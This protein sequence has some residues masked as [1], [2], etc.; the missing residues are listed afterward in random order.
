[1]VVNVKKGIMQDNSKK[2]T[3]SLRRNFLKLNFFL[4]YPLLTRHA[5]CICEPGFEGAH[6]EVNTIT[7]QNT[8][9]H[10]AAQATNSKMIGLIIGLIVML[11]LAGTAYLYFRDRKERKRARRKKRLRNAGIET[12][13]SFRGTSTGE[14]A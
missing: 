13:D 11:V 7:K 10:Y 1:M 9:G 4:T 5:G 3:S 8:M 6:C 14:L 12:P 2:P